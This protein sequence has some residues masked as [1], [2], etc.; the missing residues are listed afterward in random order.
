MRMNVDNYR[1]ILSKSGLN[2]A[3]VCKRTGLTEKSLI[4]ILDNGF[5]EIST[6]ERIADALHVPVKEISKPDPTGC[7]ENVIE[8]VKD[9][10][11]ATVTVTQGRYKSRIEKLAAERPH[12]PV[13]WIR[14]NPSMNLT[15][16]QR[17]RIAERMRQNRKKH[18]ASQDEKQKKPF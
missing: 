14:I 10:N 8:F 2:D 11:W 3:E 4:Y 15:E 13:S 1:C 7:N 18:N 6:L 17:K 9:S 5:L 16:E 12:I